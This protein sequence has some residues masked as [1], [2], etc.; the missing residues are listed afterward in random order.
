MCVYTHFGFYHLCME[1]K[2]CHDRIVIQFILEF[3]HH[4]LVVVSVA[5]GQIH[6]TMT[7]KRLYPDFLS[8]IYKF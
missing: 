7:F 6:R 5:M 8:R 1:F 3:T 2:Q 4:V